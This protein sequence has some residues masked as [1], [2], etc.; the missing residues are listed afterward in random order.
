M[1]KDTEDLAEA[2]GKEIGQL[3]AWAAITASR[4]YLLSLCAGWF[5]PMIA[6]EFWQ[7]AVVVIT[8]RTMIAPPMFRK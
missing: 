6:L 3:V 7:W 5:F 8:V 1:N 2:I 4:A